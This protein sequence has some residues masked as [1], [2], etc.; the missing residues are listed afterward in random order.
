[1]KEAGYLTVILRYSE[2]ACCSV[3]WAFCP[4]VVETLVAGWTSCREPAHTLKNPK[5][6]MYH[7]SLN[8]KCSFGSS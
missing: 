3:E 1:M 7:A 5:E 4:L 2:E 8:V 6:V